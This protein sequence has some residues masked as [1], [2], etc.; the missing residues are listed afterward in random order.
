MRRYPREH[1]AHEE[2]LEVAR[3]SPRADAVA[4]AQVLVD[5]QTGERIKQEARALIRLL[6]IDGQ[7]IS[8]VLA[9]TPDAGALIKRGRERVLIL[10]SWS[11]ADETSVTRA[12]EIARAAPSGAALVGVNVGRDVPTAVA[13]ATTLPGEQL[14]GGRGFDSPIARQLGFTRPGLVFAVTREGIVRN[15]SDVRDLGAA[16]RALN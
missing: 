10:Y 4:H 3:I 11:P 5:G 8:T 12:G 14:Y 7:H 6:T 9:G 13:K 16:V 15:L 2:L 1:G